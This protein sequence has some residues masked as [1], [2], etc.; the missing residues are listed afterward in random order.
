MLA[1]ITEHEYVLRNSEGKDDGNFKWYRSYSGSVGP[2]DCSFF[3]NSHREKCWSWEAYAHCKDLMNFPPIVINFDCCIFDIYNT[4]KKKLYFFKYFAKL[5]FQKSSIYPLSWINE[6]WFKKFPKSFAE[7]YK[8]NSNRP[9]WLSEWSK[10]S[11]Y[12]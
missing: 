9:M 1:E 4:H 11:I 12:R 10:I 3:W 5:F 6:E 2:E 7:W 8:W